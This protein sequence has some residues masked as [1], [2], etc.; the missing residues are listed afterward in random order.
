[1][2]KPITF[3]HIIEYLEIDLDNCLLTKKDFAK[4]IYDLIKN[5][6]KE[7]QQWENEIEEYYN[8][9]D[10]DIW[11]EEKETEL[12][13]SVPPCTSMTPVRDKQ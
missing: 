6:K 12:Y 8:E 3:Q 13:N 11:T 7:I 9:R 4:Y 2:N 1:M 5:P 10:R